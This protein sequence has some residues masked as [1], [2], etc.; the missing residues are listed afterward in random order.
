MAQFKELLVF[1][2]TRVLDNVYAK[3]FSAYLGTDSYYFN[4]NSQFLPI[5]EA[6]AHVVFGVNY[7]LTRNPFKRRR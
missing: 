1:G 4:M 5:H 7:L 6:N 3:K 2:T